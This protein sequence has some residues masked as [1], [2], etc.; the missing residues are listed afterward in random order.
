MT[1][2]TQLQFSRCYFDQ[3]S[4]NKET[5][6]HIFTDAST[7]AYGT[8]AYLVHDNQSTLVMTRNKVASSKKM[9]IP[10]HELMAAVLGARL[11]LHL[12]KNL[13]FEHVT[14]WSHSQIVLSWLKSEKSLPLFVKNRV[15][16][17]KEITASYEWEYCPT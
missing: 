3:F 15:T 6:L 5:K 16:E 2:C 12:M 13:Q 11:L 10:K 7:K 9:T 4:D 8:C 1:V 14:L 17:I